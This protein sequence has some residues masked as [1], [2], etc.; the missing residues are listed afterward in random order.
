MHALMF[1]HFLNLMQ[2]TIL[3]GVPYLCVPLMNLISF[4]A[5]AL[6]P[7]CLG[8]TVNRQQ[9]VMHISIQ[10]VSRL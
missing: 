8:M 7:I 5:S 10:D 4:L 6:T 2:N 3:A 9:D 1:K